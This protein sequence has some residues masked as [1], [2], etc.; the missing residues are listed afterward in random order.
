MNHNLFKNLKM[1][2]DGTW[3][4]KEKEEV[5]PYPDDANDTC[6][7]LEDKSFWFHHRA[8]CIV[9]T[10]QMYLKGRIFL[11]IGGG[12]GFMTKLIQDLGYDAFLVE[13]YKYGINNAK[14]RGVKNRIQSSL[15]K[16]KLNTA[17]VDAVGIFDVLE[18]IS[19]HG[20]FLK[21]INRILKKN[22]LIFITVPAYMFLWSEIDVHSG[23]E[24]RYTKKELNE[25]LIKCNYSPVFSTY[26]FSFMLLP[27]YILHLLKSVRRKKSKDNT[28]FLQLPKF[29]NAF[30][31]YEIWAMRRKISLPFGSSILCVAK[32]NR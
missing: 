25:L 13:P 29:I 5:I 20:G 3:I 16:M 14:S 31:Q 22:G 9:T 18:H 26:F 7:N 10:I 32:K 11:D 28:S 1:N 15:E 30:F 12:N 23:H 17:S 27:Q 21:K 19:D 6:F 24:R 8:T 2:E 4:S